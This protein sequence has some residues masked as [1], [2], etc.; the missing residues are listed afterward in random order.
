V[1]SGAGWHETVPTA[2]VAGRA[3]VNPSKRQL[4]EAVRAHAPHA[5]GTHRSTAP[6]QKLDARLPVPSARASVHAV[7]VTPRRWLTPRA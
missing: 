3:L 6:A 5:L 1:R 7:G 2:V 4:I